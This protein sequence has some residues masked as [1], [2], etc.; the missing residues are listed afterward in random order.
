[1][2]LRKITTRSKSGLFLM[3]LIIVILFF[4]IC[5]AV[6]MKIFALAKT[7]NDK[8]YNLNNASVKAESCAECYKAYDADLDL[9]AKQLKGS[10]DKNTVVVYYDDKWCE[11]SDK[12]KAVYTLTLVSTE[13][14]DINKADISVDKGKEELFSVTAADCKEG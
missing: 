13:N 4:S 3:E 2:L 7:E 14:N 10:A 11:T 1:M 6:C 5:A 9:T 12:D 8:S